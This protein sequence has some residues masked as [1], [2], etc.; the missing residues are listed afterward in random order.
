MDRPASSAAVVPPSSGFGTTGDP[1][2]AWSVD[3]AFAGHARLATPDG[4]VPLLLE[5]KAAQWPALLSSGV[6]DVA[7]AYTIAGAQRFATALVPVAQLQALASLVQRMEFCLPVQANVAPAAAAAS[8]PDGPPLIFAVIDRGCAFLHEALR[9]PGAGGRAGGTRLLGLWDQSTPVVAAASTA[10]IPGAAPA[11]F[12]YGRE[13]TPQ[14]IDSLIARMAY[15]GLDEVAVYA[16]AGYLLDDRGRLREAAHGTHVVDTGAGR[17]VG[18]T[19]RS[20]SKPDAD[21]A[22]SAVPLIFVDVPGLVEHDTTGAS[23][24]AFVLDALHYIRLRAGSQAQVVVNISLGAL[25]GPHDG[26][27]LLE[28]AMDDLLQRDGRMA[29]LLAAGNAGDGEHQRWHAFGNLDGGATAALDWRLHPEDAT[30]SFVEIWLQ[31]RDGAALPQIRLTAPG[32]EP[33]P[34]ADIGAAPQLLPAPQAAA[35]AA[36]VAAIYSRGADHWG[37][38]A[39]AL[40]AVAPCA[41]SRAAATAGVW[42]IELRGKAAAG[43]TVF[44]AWVQ[45][46]EPVFDGGLPIQ[47]S[48]DAASGGTLITGSG[49]LSNLATG[50]LTFVV[51][52]VDATAGRITRYTSR[53]VARSSTR[54]GVR[55]I[56]TFGFA[57]E[58]ATAIGLLAA[59]VR[60][61]T[62][63]RMGGTSVAAPWRARR[64]LNFLA[65]NPMPADSHLVT[66]LRGSAAMPMPPL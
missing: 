13:L 38:D 40:V 47:S 51:G 30:D 4:R 42:R 61:G 9:Q 58:S 48:F 60:S 53:G 1:Y 39:M 10:G 63:T 56:E 26:S 11:G 33:S 41:G 27:S 54:R 35:T 59:G 34:W 57:D 19:P 31:S 18:S 25:A 22:A 20:S 8:A 28:R 29:I 36:P 12:G 6:A 62:W 50:A 2:L 16:A 45:R 52:A 17:V 43:R 65:A 21:D 24:A 49:S 37:P 15:E 46:D 7:P 5:L 23:S 32:A 64:L 14:I 44:D 3:Q 55:D 66:Q